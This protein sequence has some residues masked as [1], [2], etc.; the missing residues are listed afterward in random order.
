MKVSDLIARLQMMPQDIEVMLECE[1]GLDHAMGLSITHVA[2]TERD[3]SG[4]PV[5]NYQVVDETDTE[6][7]TGNLFPVVVI[8]LDPIARN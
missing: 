6:G 8:S 7:K 3:W 2:K 1:S 5:G 4:T